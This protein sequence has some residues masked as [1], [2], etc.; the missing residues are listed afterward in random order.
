MRLH[1]LLLGVISLAVGATLGFAQPQAEKPSP[2]SSGAIQDTQS[3]VAERGVLV[4]AVQSDSPAQ[5]AG[6]VRGD[7]ILEVNGTAVNTRAELVRLVDARKSG[8]TLSVKVRHGDSEKTVSVSLSERNGRPWLGAALSPAGLGR[9]R[10]LRKRELGYQL[11]AKGAYVET[12]VAGGPA[13]K[14]GLKPGDVIVSVDGTDVDPGHSLGGLIAAKKVGDTITLSVMPSGQGQ[15][16]QSRDVKVT[17]AQNP[18]KEGPYLGV[19]YSAGVPRFGRGMP[20]P[21]MM[22]GAFVVEVSKDSPADKAGIK[23]RD[24]ITKVDGTVVSDPQEVADAVAK[25]KPGDTLSVSFYRRAED[26]DTDV[27][28][29][30]GASPN[31]ATKAYMGVSMS[32]FSGGMGPGRPRGFGGMPRLQG[33]P[34]DKA[35]KG[36]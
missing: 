23:A 6:I 26:K 33:A 10:A 35:Q 2:A 30:L 12:V 18:A 31:D 3:P 15:A 9:A 8:D 5:K 13:E 7:I 32:D 19:Q 4:V 36:I 11:P 22:A 20:G 1:P 27:T 29:T 21:A 14:A 34:P 16:R 28:V 17:L 24:L 25:H